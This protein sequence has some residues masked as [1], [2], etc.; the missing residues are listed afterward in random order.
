VAGDQTEN[1]RLILEAARALTAA[2]LS[3]FTRIGARTAVG[4]V[5]ASFPAIS[6]G[7]QSW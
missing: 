1:W 6:S 4:A 5:A 7:I 3:P 2:G